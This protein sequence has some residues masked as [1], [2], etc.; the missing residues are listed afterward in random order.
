MASA[1]G[2]YIAGI[3]GPLFA[4]AGFLIVYATII[5][6]RQD[7]NEQ[8]FDNIV[9]KIIDY[10]RENLSSMV[11]TAPVSCDR[12]EGN[13]TWTVMKANLSSAFKLL[14]SSIYSKTLD[15]T[16]KI[17]M[18]Y[19]IFYYGMPRKFNKSRALPF[20]RE[21]LK[22]MAEIDSIILQGGRL[23]HCTE[24]SH[25]FN[26]YSNKIEPI[27]NQFLSCISFIDGSDLIDL[28]KKKQYVNILINQHSPYCIVMMYFHF[29]SGI[30]PID[31]LKL[32]N[33]YSVFGTLDKKLLILND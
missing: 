16:A 6:N 14:D 4:L 24:T 23:E 8:K 32:L 13:A 22:K 27:F 12:L 1:F 10:Q 15:S 5:E 2:D 7:S 26:G 28:D 19:A 11:I 31:S 17:K 9:F 21:K 3:T 33:K 20:L 25:R 30:V 18:S 29:N